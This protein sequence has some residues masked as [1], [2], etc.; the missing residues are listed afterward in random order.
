MRWY[1]KD[2]TYGQC[3]V[4]GCEKNGTH[5]GMCPKHEARRRRTGTTEESLLSHADE[6]IRFWRRVDTS[7][8]CWLWSGA[9]NSNGYGTLRRNDGSQ[10]Y[11]HRLSYEIHNG[12]PLRDDLEVMHSC[13]RPSCVNPAHLSLATHA[14]NMA[15]AQAKGRAM[16]RRNG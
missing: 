12:G 14:E 2:K 13:D 6:K 11:A 8:D 9:V 4:D 15:D 7:A 3:A 1:A 16:W 10:V 5:S